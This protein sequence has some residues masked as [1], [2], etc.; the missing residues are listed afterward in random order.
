MSKERKSGAATGDADADIEPG[1]EPGK[2][3]LTQK[4]GRAHAPNTRVPGRSALTDRIPIAAGG[5]PL[6]LAP[7]VKKAVESATGAP[8]SNVAAWSARFGMELGHVQLVTGPAAEAAA[9]AVDARAFALGHRIFLGKG[10]QP[11]ESLL[12]H[13]LT[14]VVQQHGAPPPSISELRVTSPQETVERAADHAEG[15]AAPPVHATDAVIA[16][17]EKYTTTADYIAANKDHLCAEVPTK[18][19]ALAGSVLA[20]LKTA[21]VTWGGG[22]ATPALTGLKTA[23]ST[24]ALA[25]MKALL[26][27]RTLE[28]YVD[29]GRMLTRTSGDGVSVGDDSWAADV[30]TAV[31]DGLMRS[32]GDAVD[33]VAFRYAQAKSAAQMK[34]WAAS[35]TCDTTV[36]PEPAAADIVAG[37]PI[38]GILGASAKDMFK[39][40]LDAWRTANPALA[41][42]TSVPTVRKDVQAT[43][44]AESTAAA[45]NPGQWFI[46]LRTNPADATA[47][48]AAQAFFGGTDQAFRFHVKTA[49]LFAFS[50]SMV[51]TL[52]QD[53]QDRVV[54]M[55]PRLQAERERRKNLDDGKPH[56]I[57]FMVPRAFMDDPE[58]GAPLRDPANGL[59]PALAD[60]AA[61]AN[62][63]AQQELGPDGKPKAPRDRTEIL[64]QMGQSKV[65]L[66]DIE[67][68][69]QKMMVGA[70]AAGLSFPEGLVT[71]IQAK[72]DARRQKLAT[73]PDADVAAWD[74]Q[75]QQQ[76]QVIG[77][78]I[79]GLTDLDRQ[80]AALDVSGGK[81]P[82]AMWEIA[83]STRLPVIRAAT[84]YINAAA[85][86]DLPDAARAQ[87]E[88]AKSQAAIIPAEMMDLVL[89]QIQTM[90]AGVK[91][92]DY[93]TTEMSHKQDKL[94]IGVA[95]LRQALLARSPEAKTLM[96]SLWT[97]IEDLQTSGTIISNMDGLDQAWSAMDDLA[98]S[99]GVWGDADKKLRDLC[100]EAKLWK[101]KWNTIR[102]DWNSAL[103]D[104]AGP[105]ESKKKEVK[106]RFDALRTAPGLADFLGRA[107]GALKDAAKRAMVARL[108][109]LL[110]ITVVTMGVGTLVS[111][112]AA[113]AM[114][115]ATAAEATG[116]AAFAIGAAAT[117]A[118]ATTA[119]ALNEAFFAK[120][121]DWGNFAEELVFN[122]MLFGAMRAVSAALQVGKLG[123]FLEENAAAKSGAEISAQSVTGV[124]GTALKTAYDKKGQPLTAEEKQDIITQTVAT[125]VA[126]AVLARV[127]KPMLQR[128]EKAGAGL[129]AAIKAANEARALAAAQAHAVQ[130]G[131][132][133]LQ[134]VKELLKLDGESLKA[135]IKALEETKRAATSPEGREALKAQGMSDADIASLA[136]S[137]PRALV[138]L[139]IAEAVG[140]A[141]QVGG[142][143]FN[144]PK[145][146]LP[147]LL[148]RLQKA[149][150][151]VK[152]SGVDKITN[153]RVFEATF[154]DG[155]IVQVFEKPSAPRVGAVPGTEPTPDEAEAMR[156]AA[157]EAEVLIKARDQQATD[158]ALQHAGGY[159]VLDDVII[160]AGQAGVVANSAMSGGAGEA[161][162]GVDIKALPRRINIA[163]EGSM[164]SKHGDFPIGQTPDNHASP[165]LSHQPGE[166]HSDH[167]K[168]V[169]AADLVRAYTMTAL[170]S[171]QVTVKMRVTNVE[172]NPK[173]GTWP[174]DAAFRVS[175]D[176]GVTIYVK[177][178]VV[179]AMGLGGAT[180][181]YVKGE[182]ALIDAGKLVFAADT[183]VPPAGSKKVL[184]IGNGP[185]G[186][187]AVEKALAMGLEVVWQGRINPKEPCPPDIKA[188]MQAKGMNNEQIE[189]FWK[190]F[191]DRTTDL[192]TKLGHKSAFD[193]LGKGPGKVE[194]RTVALDEATVQPDGSVKLG[195]LSV[196]GVIA[197]TGQNPNP[198]PGLADLHY[199]LVIVQVDGK[200][201]LV[202]LDPVDASG[203][204]IPGLRLVGAQALNPKMKAMVVSDQQDQFST[205]LTEG[206][207]DG[208]PALSKGVPGSIFHS[209]QTVP[210]AVQSLDPAVKPAPPKPYD[211]MATPIF[212]DQQQDEIRYL[213][214]MMKEWRSFSLVYAPDGSLISAVGFDAEDFL[215]DGAE[216]ERLYHP[217]ALTL[218][219]V[220]R[221]VAALVA[222]PE[223][224][225]K[226]RLMLRGLGD[227]G[228]AV[229]GAA[230]LA[231][232]ELVLEEEALTAAGVRALLPLAPQ[233]ELLSLARNEIGDDGA[234][235]IAGAPFAALRTLGL[236]GCQ[237]RDAGAV[238][239][240]RSTHL[241]LRALDLRSADP[242]SSPWKNR[243]GEETGRA[244]AASPWAAA[245]E[246]LQLAQT[247]LG[248][249]GA[250]AL[251]GVAAPGPVDSDLR[252][253]YLENES[254]I[255]SLAAAPWTRLGRLG[256]SGNHIPSDEMQD[257]YDY[258]G[259]VVARGPR[260]RTAGELAQRSGFAGRGVTVY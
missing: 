250:A 216:L 127:A 254:T 69:G 194:M 159:V 9:D 113:G 220:G 251:A 1:L 185:T 182:K 21:G 189:G 219:K 239:L 106:G 50:S 236:R 126:A 33:R 176:A 148:G 102:V 67:K 92:K 140:N 19:D 203:K 43:I 257:S 42:A 88:Q 228:A 81:T 198:F 206:I 131:T 137:L 143:N 139:K 39:V 125:T 167:S 256:L 55:S 183:L 68:L 232:R 200:P 11:T 224:A 130:K 147:G 90:I 163:P 243:F 141:E 63:K 34:A 100:A 8:L 45:E 85:S 110:A 213:L 96:T 116:G 199:K 171:G 242:A 87:L 260:P 252:E 156:K 17:D 258:D 122:A 37:H 253:C 186:E 91:G 29:R 170:E 161:A 20:R 118:E 83:R 246:I 245:L 238:A 98:D 61:L 30:A 178:R 117:V 24:G 121:W 150:A 82:P 119:A 16:R 74:T 59:P 145:E 154:E 111:G 77:A 244:L 58:A 134:G 162:P 95:K 229:L 107:Q 115:F 158:L 173:D 160:G 226:R 184:I 218:Y 108:I 151:Q 201:K 44:A 195:D 23:I 255:A 210:A 35:K 36:Q 94:R 129:G 105:N 202:G 40:D 7:T 75:A 6:R 133:D 22:G 5:A 51:W 112:V 54:G 138:R 136:K 70:D 155:S 215:R 233:L 124:V 80:L 26:V 204:V 3:S 212:P 62:A 225:A 72:L 142:D 2:R 65:L 101:T 191:N 14:H 52:P 180:S 109:A 31:A 84:A 76:N 174:V 49:P 78:V 28:Q 164:F 175:T 104:P 208:V 13:E 231:V 169:A 48:E 128:L 157:D 120:K 168:P 47:E 234:E 207:T 114:G 247:S 223:F 60:E 237:L 177:G 196:D 132:A 153:A 93:D 152:T 79:A 71:S 25:T 10:V 32:L 66:G 249:D 227:A 197:A 89:G 144:V 97:E 149:G 214:A 73:A 18:L 240:A 209:N 12:A 190:A 222:M 181:S 99:F 165:A 41:N 123:V 221:H 230:P 248:D 235:A 86:S 57:G 64:S 135:D 211:P 4:L 53:V 56:L 46:W 188:K 193:H 217:P 146:D 179:G 205:L 27:P 187:W 259:T 38:D 166:F 103:N 15:G 172:I 192:A 241:R